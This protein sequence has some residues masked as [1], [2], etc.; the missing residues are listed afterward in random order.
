M[1]LFDSKKITTSTMCTIGYHRGYLHYWA[2]Q[3][4]QRL[5]VQEI[6]CASL[7]LRVPQGTIELCLWCSMV[8]KNLWCPMEPAMCDWAPQIL[9]TLQ[10]H[11]YYMHH[12]TQHMLIIIL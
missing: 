7:T 2:L 6:T 10:G 9:L 4:P 5:W 1:V 11:R 12:W 8:P 3:T